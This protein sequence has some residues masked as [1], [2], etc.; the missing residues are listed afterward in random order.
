MALAILVMCDVCISILGKNA[1]SHGS[2]PCIL[3]KSLYCNLCSVYGHSVSL[4]KRRGLRYFR[5]TDGPLIEEPIIYDV[6]DEN[7]LVFVSDSERAFSAMLIANKLV[8]MACQEKGRFDER[9]YHENKS[10]LVEF[11]KSV[12]KKLILVSIPWVSIEDNLLKELVV[13]YP[14]EWKQVA[15]RMERRTQEHC[16][17]RWVIIN[18]KKIRHNRNG[19]E[20]TKE[21]LKT[22][23]DKTA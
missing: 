10:R 23:D 11:L 4:C 14:N 6:P 15:S 12:G 17:A 9:D 3:A 22:E 18:S 2:N 21:A 7:N 20:D 13:Q 8:P 5:I 16:K 19:K 1:R